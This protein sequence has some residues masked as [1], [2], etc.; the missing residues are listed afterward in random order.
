LELAVITKILTRYPEILFTGAMLAIMLLLSVALS[1]PIILPSTE[2]AEFL[3]IHYLYPLIGIGFWFGFAVVGQRRD[4]PRIFLT[5]FPCYALVQWAYFNIKLW[6]PYINPV[7]FDQIYWEIDQH[8][9]PLVDMAFDIRRHTAWLVP[10]HGNFY[11]VGF[12]MMF[13]VS[14]CYHA[15]RTPEKFR[16]V[17]LAALF[18]QG[19]GTLAY[20]PFPALGPFLFEPGVN[21]MMTAAQADMLN[22]HDKIVRHGAGWLS[23]HGPS[24]ITAGLAA[25]PSLHAGGSFLFLLLAWRHARILLPLYLPLTFYILVAAVATRWHYLIDLPIGVALA[26]VSVALAEKLSGNASPVD[27]EPAEDV[28]GAVPAAV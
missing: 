6:V 14:F 25:M 7:S 24:N 27:K 21:E 18:F 10:L 17:F 28:P 9:R 15:L 1:L 8:L 12:I 16:T 13:Y 19:L 3:G 11:M 23:V 26:R 5:A 22:F 20:I 4:L 2:R